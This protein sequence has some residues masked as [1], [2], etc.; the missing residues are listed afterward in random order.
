MQGAE[1]GSANL[2]FHSGA[3]YFCALFAVVSQGR[4]FGSKAVELENTRVEAP[5]EH[6]NLGAGVAVAAALLHGEA[7]VAPVFAMFAM[8]GRKMP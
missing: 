8:D 3:L 6:V 1:H 7:L 5:V 2:A 4:G